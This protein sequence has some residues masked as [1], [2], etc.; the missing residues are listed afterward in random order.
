MKC[1]DCD[2]GRYTNGRGAIMQCRRCKGTGEIEHIGQALHSVIVLKVT[3]DRK[4]AYVRSTKGKTLA[5]WI[6]D[7]LDKESGYSPTRADRH[8]DLP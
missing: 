4:A 1:H 5:S 3:T 8:C 6:F 2:R 7:L